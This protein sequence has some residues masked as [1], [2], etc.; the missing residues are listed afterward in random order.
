[1]FFV[2]RIIA[3]PSD[4]YAFLHIWRS[5]INSAETPLNNH[6]CPLF[7]VS[8]R[9]IH[10]KD[11]L[12]LTWLAMIAA[13]HAAALEPN[14]VKRGRPIFRLLNCE[15]PLPANIPLFLP[16]YISVLDMCSHLESIRAANLQCECDGPRMKCGSSLQASDLS[17]IV[18]LTA[19]A[20]L[21]LNG[22]VQSRS[23]S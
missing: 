12:F 21:R 7:A 8:A 13:V 11:L 19:I 22:I 5:S 9:P 2:H 1:M 20:G 3:N 16:S 15:G 14:P 18:S 4:Q 17:I 6:Q 10:H 23:S